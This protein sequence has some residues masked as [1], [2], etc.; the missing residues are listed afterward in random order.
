M[1]LD[2][3]E[4]GCRLSPAKDEPHFQRGA[5]LKRISRFHLL[6]LGLVIGLELPAFAGIVLFDFHQEFNAAKIPVQD[7]TV[8]LIHSATG[9]ALQ[10]R[11][12][13]RAPWPGITLVA[14]EGHWDLSPY[15]WLALTVRN[16]GTNPVTVNCRVDNPGADGVNHCVTGSLALNPLQAGT[17]RVELKRNSSSTLGGKLFGMRGY[18]VA[19]GGPGTIAAT[20]V[21]QLLVFVSKPDAGHLF[22]IETIRAEGTF[23][24]PTASV[25]DAAPFFP[26]I[27]TFGQYR[28]KD[29][30]G[31]THSV[32]ELAQRRDAELKDLSGQ[33][34]PGNWD[35]FGG[36]KSGPQLDATG[37]F[38]AEKVHGKWWLV[39][40]DGRLFFSHG[41][42]CVGA[43]D[44]TPVDER[45][46]WFQDFPGAQP[47][48][49]EFLVRGAFALKGHYAGTTPQCF[50]F[51]GAN[52]RRKYGPDWRLRS[53]EIVHRRLRSYGLNTIGMWSDATTRGMRRTAY[54]DAVSST[55]SK[56]LAGSDGYWG[57][58]PDVF[59][60]SFQ[61]RLRE[62]MA[63]KT[64]NSAG[65]PWCLGYFSDNEMSWG[66]E[67]SLAVAAL[68][69][70]PEQA[71]KKVFVAD[72]KAT[73]GDIGKLNKVWD[74]HHES[75]D[76]LLAH[77]GAPDR[78]KARR[79]LTNFYTRT[80]EQYFRTVR[81]TIKSVA[82]HQ[83]YL[84]CR[85]A[86]VNARAAAAAA[87]YCDVVS[88]NL[89]RRS[90]ADF[91]F[92]GGADVPL[93]IGE[94]HLGALDRGMFHTGLVPTNDQAERAQIYKDYVRGVLRHPAFVGCH[95]FQYQDEPT[96]GR[97]YDEENYQ[98]GLFDIA[99]T[100]YRETVEACREVGYDLYR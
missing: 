70:P 14:P 68:S 39:D 57:K 19:P 43:I 40:P 17:L 67:V 61:S 3:R 1:N 76:A 51:L 10:V 44:V 50:S 85:F 92:N 7:A 71:A 31:K 53:A 46:D 81:E 45:R 75:W 21:N 73:Y 20:N 52:L 55:R 37:F 33:P 95:W 13:H 36:W 99:D 6:F 93:I 9:S 12:G 58:F 88:Y 48:F 80:A 42:D 96:T 90:V 59:D 30:P 94:F 49:Q 23:T 38:R 2:A 66:D 32:E 15:A 82:P 84:G 28:H 74:T 60:P 63:A 78:Q 5:R 89:Y 24:A 29:W 22:Q 98:I 16:P 64:G 97:V 47:E 26:F 54:V 62:S 8:S 56:P 100:P 4:N 87:R 65:D 25:D 27:D 69:S 35:R 18:P 91:Q 41:V 11:T 86:W 83:L 79:D 34:G 72:L 77:R